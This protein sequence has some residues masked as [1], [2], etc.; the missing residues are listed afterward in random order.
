MYAIVDV[1]TTGLSPGAEKITEIAIYLHDGKQIVDEFQSLINPEKKR[2]S[3]ISIM[4]QKFLSWIKETRAI[5]VFKKFLEIIV[6]VSIAAMLIAPKIFLSALGVLFFAKKIL[7][8]TFNTM[9]MM[10]FKSH[11]TISK[12]KDCSTII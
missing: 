7:S 2:D 9:T 1:E 3:M 11:I 8:C 5:I 10:T 6:A 4:Y 12:N